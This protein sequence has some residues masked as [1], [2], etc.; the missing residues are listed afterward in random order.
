L[1]GERKVDVTTE[2]QRQQLSQSPPWR[3]L[4]DNLA[5]LGNLALD[6]KWTWS[7]QTDHI[8]RTI[9]PLTWDITANPWLILQSASQNRLEELS[10]DPGFVDAVRSAADERAAYLA[11]PGWYGGKYG[12]RPSQLKV[13]YF[14]MEFGLC[15]S[16]AIYAGGLGILAGDFLKAS[17]DLAMP[18]MGIGLLYQ[19]GYFRQVLDE[20]GRQT[21]AYPYNDPATLP[22]FP[23]HDRRGKWLSVPVE[24]P[25]RVVLLRVWRANV[26]RVCLYLLDTN[27]WLNSASDRGIANKLYVDGPERR[28][29]QEIVLGIGGWRTLK[30]LGIEIN[31]LHL[32]EGHTAFAALERARDLAQQIGI[33]FEQAVWATRGGTVFT[34]HTPVVAG[35]DAFEPALIVKYVRDYS[36]HLGISVDDFLALGR[37]RAN[38]DDEPFNMAF[39]AARLSGS[40]NAVSRVHEH[41]TRKMASPAF[42]RWPESDLPISHVTN[43]IHTPSWDSQ[44]SDQLWTKLCGKERWLGELDGVPESIA[45]SSDEA[46]WSMRTQGRKALVDYARSRLV[47]SLGQR[48]ADPTLIERGRYVLDPNILTLGMAR[49]FASYKRA[50]LILHDLGRM[51]RILLDPVHRVQ[52]VVA[53]KAHPNDYEGKMLIQEFTRLAGEHDLRDRVVFLEDYDISSA[54]RMVGGVDVWIN[55]PRRTWEACGT[56]GMK[57]LVNGG[58]NL[59]TLD[60]WW[61]EAY[62]SDLGWALG[63]HRFDD[64]DDA[65]EE[66]AHFYE[67]LERDLIPQF[68]ERDLDG[69]PRAWI[70]R[71][72]ASMATLTAQFSANRMARE[73]LEL[74]YLGAADSFARRSADNARIACELN[75]WREQ[76]RVGWPHLRF[77]NLHIDEIPEKNAFAVEVYMGEMKPDLVRVELYADPSGKHSV[78]RVAMRRGRPIEGTINAYFFEAETSGARPADHYTPRIIP[79]H[80]EARIPLE[81]I[82]VLWQR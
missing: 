46:I 79:Y 27:H 47:R 32:N 8:W 14:S 66:A 31:I 13:A 29:L 38:H 53:G 48:G 71:V 82:H 37:T 57:V 77:G 39:L 16:L 56:S 18:V 72:R 60:G 59:S 40:A 30:A 65:A 5:E 73:Y 17:S 11:H 74:L 64:H 43:G 78:E 15:E 67:I 58:L 1:A 49:R 50:T 22:I 51:K 54:Q 25:G 61:V 3:L 80:P 34:S 63:D 33:S 21:E 20:V 6:L 10:H 19:E 44:D 28:L 41:V 70:A 23:A 12:S 36:D 81:D 2:G 35:F 68:Y 9:D 24:L 52:L 26:G 55:T 45:K 76:I 62:R 4:P 69:L 42:P 75:S 7:H